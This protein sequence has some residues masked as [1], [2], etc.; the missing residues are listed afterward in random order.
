MRA[1]SFHIVSNTETNDWRSH[2]CRMAT[3]CL[4]ILHELTLVEKACGNPKKSKRFIL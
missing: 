4:Q 1:E 2:T 3:C